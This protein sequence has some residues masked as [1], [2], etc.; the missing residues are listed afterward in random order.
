M[1][2]YTGR[3]AYAVS[4]TASTGTYTHTLRKADYVIVGLPHRTVINYAYDGLYRLTDANYSTGERFQY[5]YDPVGNRT[6]QTATIT[7]TQVTAYQFDAANRLTSV[8]GQ[9]YTWD[10]NGNLVSDGAK[11]YTYNQANQLTSLTQGATTFQ[12]N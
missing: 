7:S 6:A 10:D 4:L 1:H 2:V 12:F 9:A 5:A 8:N 11:T 3:G